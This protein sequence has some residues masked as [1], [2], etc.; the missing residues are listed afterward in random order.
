MAALVAGMRSLANANQQ[1][2][3]KGL[4]FAGSALV[5][6][7]FVWALSGALLSMAINK[8]SGEEVGSLPMQEENICTDAAAMGAL[9]REPAGVVAGPS[10]LGSH[11][12]RFT[13]H[14]VL[15]APYHRNQGGMLTELHAAIATPKDAI[16]FLRGAGVTVVAFCKSDP[17]VRSISKKAPDGFYA[18]LGKGI[19]PVWLEPV[20][21]TQDQPLELFRVKP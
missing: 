7:P 18:Q 1:D 3:R 17:Q 14:R 5:A 12:L 10:N 11:I 4:A 13:P 6:V 2:L 15:A 8:V 9:A 19:V 21:G 20:P 16:K